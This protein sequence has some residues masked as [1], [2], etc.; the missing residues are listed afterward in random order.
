MM[1]LWRAQRLRGH[2]ACERATAVAMAVGEGDR[3]AVRLPLQEDCAE[4]A[5]L[6]EADGAVAGEVLRSPDLQ[7]FRGSEV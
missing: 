2:P 6:S 5:V 7:L 4:V 3:E 1:L